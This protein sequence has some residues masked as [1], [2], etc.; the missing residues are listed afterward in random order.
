MHHRAYWAYAC[1]HTN[2]WRWQGLIRWHFVSQAGLL[3]PPATYSEVLG[4]TRS[5]LA[6][7]QSWHSKA[8]KAPHAS[9]VRLIS[10]GQTQ[11]HT[12]STTNSCP[13]HS[14][15]HEHPGLLARR[16]QPQRIW[17]RRQQFTLKR[18][19]L[20]SNIYLALARLPASSPAT[21]MI[22]VPP[23]IGVSTD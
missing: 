1:Q 18:G 23:S 11:P 8:T 19:C 21:A 17:Q 16:H 14:D 4:Q 13:D 22:T 20:E 6:N 12:T 15:S 7:W 9:F 10:I 2:R 5:I 3:G